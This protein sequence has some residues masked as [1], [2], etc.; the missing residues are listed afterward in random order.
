[1]MAPSP[2]RQRTLA[3]LG[4]AL[5]AAAQLHPWLLWSTRDLA[6]YAFFRDDG[7]F[8][9][10]L[11]ESF[12]RHGV[13]SFDGELATNGVQPLWMGL[14]IGAKAL[15]PAIDAS[16]LLARLSFAAYVAFAYA[17]ALW[18]WRGSGVRAAA[19][20]AV[21]AAGVLVNPAFEYFA[22]RGLETPLA[23]LLLMVLLLKLDAV[24]ARDRCT[25]VDAASLALLCALCFL[26]RTHLFW[27]SIVLF[28]WILWRRPRSPLPAAIYAGVTVA[29]VGPYLAFNAAIFGSPMPI[30]GRVKRFYLETLHPTLGDYVG[31]VEWHG[32]FSAFAESAWVRFQPPM[33]PWAVVVLLVLV[34][35]LAL[36]I[37]DLRRD[38][39]DRRLPASLSLLAVACAANLLLMYGWYRELRPYSS[40]YFAGEV[41]FAV[42][43]VAAWL[44]TTRRPRTVAAVAIVL[45]AVTSAFRFAQLEPSDYWRSHL[46]VLDDLRDLPADATIGAYWPGALG[47]L[48]GRPVLPLDGIISSPEYFEEWVRTGRDLD[49][50][51]AHP[52]PTLAIYLYQAPERL[53]EAPAPPNVPHWNRLGELRLWSRRDC[54]PRI[55]AR[56]PR[57]DD[58]KGWYVI[59]FDEAALARCRRT[60]GIP[61]YSSPS[62]SSS[63]SS[64]PSST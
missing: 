38:P 53:L 46:A 57:R 6:A 16:T 39:E 42:A 19:G 34:P 59:S 51:L 64:P 10:V 33:V 3:A 12:A 4:V 28:G 22:V 54:G 26:A 1:M 55:V 32:V 14:L 45:I 41:V 13:L 27:L 36:A 5:V 23:L 62:S 25:S 43:L 50:L 2:G 11:A 8:Y 30:S 35:L 31:S 63:T 47:A 48:S 20:L 21:F 18:A 44:Q 49:W 56:H 24:A 9:A 52:S 15:F 37:R 61:S 29:L 60:H 7:F 58:G 17:G 40:Y